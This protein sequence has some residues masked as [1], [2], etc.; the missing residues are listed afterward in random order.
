MDRRR[1]TPSLEGL[2]GRALLSGLFGGSTATSNTTISVQ[3]LPSTYRQKLNRIDHLPFYLNQEDPGRNLPADVVSKLQADITSVVSTLHAP[4]TQVVDTFNV[5]LRDLMTSKTLSRQSAY[6]LNQSFGAVLTRAGATPEQVGNL[7]DDMNALARLDAASS[8][9]ALLA[10]ED[11]AL[12]LQT[13]LA[14][15]RPIET[16]TAPILAATDGLRAKDNASAITRDHNPTLV[17]TYQ[18]GAT[19][20]GYILMQ[21]IDADGR[22]L[23]SGVV[24]AS[25]QYSVKLSTYLPDGTYELR[26]RASDEVGHLSPPSPHAFRLKV[27]SRPGEAATASTTTTTAASTPLVSVTTTTTAPHAAAE[28]LQPP[29]GPLGLT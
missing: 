4:T 8:Q 10:R 9:P 1:L 28:T 12:V 14:V 18:P 3:D 11:Y 24:N 7:K 16:P 27:L 5:G 23:G 25:G 22:V 21:I 20:V 19:K 15:G 29:R 6:R 13:T 26:A 2:E 17:G